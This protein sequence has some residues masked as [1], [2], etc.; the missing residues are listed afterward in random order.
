MAKGWGNESFLLEIDCS[1]GSR[2]NSQN[3]WMN[4]N[5][6]V[7][8]LKITIWGAQFTIQKSFSFGGLYCFFNLLLYA[9]SE[10][11]F[12]GIIGP[13]F[14]DPHWFDDHYFLSSNLVNMFSFLLKTLLIYQLAKNI[15]LQC[16][17]F[18]D[19][20]SIPQ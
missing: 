11:N 4:C 6:Q 1:L 7:A 9:I 2:V 14:H 5:L 19:W 17:V 18:D 10:H 13:L 12:H 20:D 3:L 15:M 16:I 8:M